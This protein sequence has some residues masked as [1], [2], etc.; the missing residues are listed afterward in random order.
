M[1]LHVIH[2]DITKMAV[3]AIVNSADPLPIFGGGVEAAINMKAGPELLRKRETF[4]TLA[5]GQIVVSPAYRLKAKYVFHAVGP[6][7]V[8]GANNERSRLTSVYVRAL[9][10]ALELGL[11]SIAF[12]LISAGL[13][14][15]PKQAALDIA[16]DA[17]KA[18][19][20]SHRLDVYLVIYDKES[21]ALY[22]SRFESIMGALAQRNI[23]EDDYFADREPKLRTESIKRSYREDQE[24]NFANINI[25]SAV[26]VDFSAHKEKTFSQALFDFIRER[27][28]D[29]VEVYTRAHLDKKLFS[30][31]R[32]NNYHPKRETAIALCLALKLNI[33]ETLDLLKRAGYTLSMSQNFDLIIRYHIEHKQFDIMKINDTLDDYSEPLL[34]V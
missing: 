28:Y 7:W 19:L 15:F 6:I 8:G 30:K 3:D 17:I 26:A 29:D 27:K 25:E 24:N 13:Y 18:F 21:F 1:P 22:E 12:P 4:G 23:K 14:G 2:Q 10:L 5:D 32:G 16:I 34:K 9:D 31:I 11:R 33:D 20:L